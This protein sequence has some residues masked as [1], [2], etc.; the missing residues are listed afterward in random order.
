M[1]ILTYS[2]TYISEYIFILKR[3]TKLN[4]CSKREIKKKELPM[5]KCARYVCIFY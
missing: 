4:V 3:L 5:I 1:C 2:H